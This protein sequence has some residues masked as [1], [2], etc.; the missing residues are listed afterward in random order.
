MSLGLI[1]WLI[2]LALLNIGVYMS[3]LG[4]KDQTGTGE[5]ADGI[6]FLI[7]LVLVVIADISTVASVI[8]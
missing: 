6:G 7:F 2:V 1:I 8:L 5:L 4:V 3:W